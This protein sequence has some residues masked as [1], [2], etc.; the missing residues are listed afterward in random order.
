M[1]KSI[2]LLLSLCASFTCLAQTK[3]IIR[4]ID[5]EKTIK[6]SKNQ[7]IEFSKNANKSNSIV[8]RSEFVKFDDSAIVVK[9][10]ERITRENLPFH[11]VRIV[12]EFKEDVP[13][14]KINFE[15]F[16][17]V[18]IDRKNDREIINT[19]AVLI[20]SGFIISA[21]I[22]PL[23]SIRQ[24]DHINRRLYNTSL[25]TGVGMIGTGIVIG[26]IFIKSEKY[27]FTNSTAI[28]KRIW[29]V[30]GTK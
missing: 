11:K 29:K 4:S 27:H 14:K 2:Y 3:L 25:L 30:I 16:E 8:L 15:E 13:F 24:G 9:P 7:Q 10:I 1:K 19:T 23:I 21:I 28:N 12:E 20:T 26:S 6:L 18:R 17:L 22:A 5:Q